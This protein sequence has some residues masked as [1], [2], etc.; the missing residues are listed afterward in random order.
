MSTI[1]RGIKNIFRS[2]LR[3]IGIAT[4]LA[5]SLSLGFSMLLANK[6]V[7]E[8]G[9]QLRQTIGANMVVFP[10]G[11][12]GGL[13]SGRSFTPE[14]IEKIKSAPGVKNVHKTLGFAIQD[15]KEVSEKKPAEKGLIIESSGLDNLPTTNLRSAV[16]PSKEKPPFNKFPTPPIS[17][18]GLES[19]VGSDG[20]KI[21][22]TIGRFLQPNDT[23]SA[24]IGK[25]LAEK[26]KLSVGSTFTIKDKQFTVVGIFDNGT[27][28]ANNAIVIPL[29]TAQQLLDKKDEA[30]QVI[31]EAASIEAMAKAKETIAAALGKDRVD[32]MPLRPEA[33]QLV[34]SLK[35]IEGI[36]FVTLIVSLAAALVT[37]LM[38]MLL[39]VRE[40]AKEIG[41]LKALGGTNAKIVMQFLT[42]AT[43]LTCLSAIIG[44]AFAALSSNAILRG[45]LDARINTPASDHMG[46]T[47]QAIGAPG[48][49]SPQ[50]LVANLS[51]ILDWQFVLLGFGIALGIA[52][53]GT[54]I[55]AFIIAKV[56]PAQIMRGN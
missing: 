39:V 24:V 12:S 29:K 34:E 8:R 14:E 48:A 54:A 26:N 38:A 47:V 11:S 52:L 28:F 25:D 50:E 2:G 5:V 42:E 31:V 3:T 37:I 55:P 36:S 20:K 10:A 44:I 41:I 53:I 35:S 19:N 13:E 51:T 46:G 43:V 18:M 27:L 32:I 21:V 15:P 45:I 23:L 56:R 22:P 49:S 30:P 9:G 7:S 40:R 1:V 16:D 17:V 6:A 33:V 4:I